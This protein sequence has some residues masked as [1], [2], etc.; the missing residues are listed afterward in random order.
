MSYKIQLNFSEPEL[1][2]LVLMLRTLETNIHKHANHSERGADYGFW[3]APIQDKLKVELAKNR[4]EHEI[5]AK[6][7]STL[8]S[9][10]EKACSDED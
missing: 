9:L 10:L 6:L 7:V 4:V 3:D 5:N 8:I 2:K 1:H